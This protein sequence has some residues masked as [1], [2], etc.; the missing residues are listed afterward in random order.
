[1][2]SK[3]SLFIVKMIV[4]FLHFECHFTECHFAECHFAECHFAECHFAEC[5]FAEC[6]GNDII[7]KFCKLV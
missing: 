4:R 3:L 6:I 5:H 7:C 2:L 1:M